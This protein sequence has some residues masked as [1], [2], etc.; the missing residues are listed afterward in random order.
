MLVPSHPCLLVP[1]LEPVDCDVEHD[2]LLVLARRP[3]GHLELLQRVL[4]HAVAARLLHL[5][6]ADQLPLE[7]L[8]VAHELV[9]VPRTP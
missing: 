1:D 4:A 5:Q 7:R 2:P 8:P 6:H 3:D 9:L